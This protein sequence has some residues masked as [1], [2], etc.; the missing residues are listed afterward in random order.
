MT[1]END[2]DGRMIGDKGI[3]GRVMDDCNAALWILSENET[4]KGGTSDT[5]RVAVLL[6]RKEH[7]GVQVFDEDRKDLDKQDWNGFGHDQ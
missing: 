2:D 5:M 6:R 7:T 3:I 1:Y 4:R